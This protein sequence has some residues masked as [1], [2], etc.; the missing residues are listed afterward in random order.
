MKVIEFLPPYSPFTVL[1][2][3]D[4]LTILGYNILW[5]SEFIWIQNSLRWGLNA[6]DILSWFWY[7]LFC[8]I[9]ELYPG[10]YCSEIDLW[11]PMFLSMK[12]HN[13]FKLFGKTCIQICS[14]A[15]NGCVLYKHS[16]CEQSLIELCIQ[17]S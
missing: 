16:S 2:A 1:K 12:D 10:L 8:G 7:S 14:V 11:G 3:F 6:K 13:G 15:T 9:G 4:N 5:I 17:F